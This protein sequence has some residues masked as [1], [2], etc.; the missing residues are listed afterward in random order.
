MMTKQEYENAFQNP[1]VL[2]NV[3]KLKLD[4]GKIVACD[5]YNMRDATYFSFF[6][7]PG[8]YD[9]QLVEI[10]LP[11]YGERIAYAR[12]LFIPG[13]E[14]ASMELARCSNPMNHIVGSGLSSFMDEVTRAEF[15]RI[16]E[17]FYGDH[18][19]GNYYTDINQA[20]FK[21]SAKTTAPGDDGNWAMHW[22]PGSELNVAMFSSGLGDGE[23]R[24][25]WAR[26]KY[27]KIV[28]L[29]TD[30]GIVSKKPR[31]QKPKTEPLKPEP[32]KTV[33]RKKNGAIAQSLSK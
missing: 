11:D 5:P 3:G 32:V 18:P 16:F 31:V 21:K 6:V 24:S 14:M 12:I 1:N 27:G 8:N 4:S 26:N 17:K 20:E 23:Y 22:L 30:F 28:A 29:V 33:L 2:I 9:V 10:S 15:A 19:K 25:Y 7:P 13:D